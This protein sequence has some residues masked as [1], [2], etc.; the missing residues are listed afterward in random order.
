MQR[1]SRVV[2]VA[3]FAVACAAARGEVR[4]A[5]AETRALVEQQ[6]L[7]RARFDLG[8]ALSFRN[9]SQNASQVDVAAKGLA[10]SHLRFDG[11]VWFGGLPLGLTA[12]ASWE[13]FAL[14]GTDFAGADVS[15]G[16]DSYAVAGGLATRFDLY[17]G[18][19][20]EA[21]LGYEYASLPI[22]DASGAAMAKGEV[23]T[24]GP[25]IAMRFGLPQGSWILPDVHASVVPYAMSATPTGSSSGWAVDAGVGIGFGGLNLGG[26]EWSAVLGYDFSTT[27]VSGG[28]GQFIQRAHRASLGLRLSIP[29][30]TSMVEPPRPTGPGRI[31]GRLLDP[32]GNPLARHAV[33]VE[34][35]AEPLLTRADGTFT[36]KKAGPGAV[37]LRAVEPGLKP[38]AQT[39]DVPP[40]ADVNVELQLARPS[41]PGTIRGVVYDKPADPSKR[42][43][44]AKAV[45]QA[46]GKSFETDDQG[47]FAIPDVG[48]GL[49]Q[50]KLSAKGFVSGEEVVQV[51]PEAEAKVELSLLREKVKPLATLR[52]VVRGPGGKPLAAKLAIPEAKIVSQ[53]NAAGEFKVQVPGGKYK[54]QVDAPGY[55]A[56]TKVVQVADGD[57]AIFNIDMHPTR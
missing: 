41:G 25:M 43:A 39:V 55:I 26:L 34:G 8:Y 42:V 50:L 27:Q 36:V 53:T 24:H 45:V 10:P 3:A 7:P 56:Q 6:D 2:A 20:L 35:A 54:V 33:E 16:V 40:E 18:W 57:Q 30:A 17:R 32:D 28:G 1:R 13:R 4:A 14:K 23:S 9:D 31:F 44:V 48:P 51:P 12:R 29:G 5:E 21:A 47:A 15:F 52:G 22:V 19:A 38:A 49:V 11:A 37:V 46:G